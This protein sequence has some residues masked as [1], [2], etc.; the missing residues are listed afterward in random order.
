MEGRGEIDPDN[1]IEIDHLQ[2]AYDGTVV[3]DIDAYSF[4]RG[5][6]YALV[7]PNGSGKSTLLMI[8]SLLAPFTSGR[9]T[10]DGIDISQ[11]DPHEI[12]KRVTL[13]HQE[14]VMF[15]ASVKKNA[16]MGLIYRDMPKS[17]M[18]KRISEALG[19]VGM[20][21]LEHRNART[22][23]GGEKKRTAIA[24][25]LAVSP[26]ILLFDEPTANV[27]A[28]NSAKIEEIIRTINDQKKTTI[29]FSTHNLN[30]AYRL[31]DE[32]LTLMYGRPQ[33]KSL[34][35]I[36]SGRPE[37]LDK[38]PVFNTGR[39]LIRLPD[40]NP[41]I[42]QISIDPS[43]IIISKNA[44]MTSA[45]NLFQGQIVELVK[46]AHLIGVTVR[47][48]EDFR[49]TITERSFKEMGLSIGEDVYIA[50]KATAVTTY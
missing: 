11:A 38:E 36:F 12:R 31:S 35:N 49:V 47:A 15:H 34:S 23:S 16:A 8:L 24:R 13:V 29:I 48:E 28:T 37:L 7:G 1:I 45:R 14:P 50:F 9:V 32:V 44:A 10:L 39:I 40:L 19:A 46:N 6:V 20:S 17:E 30:Q 5:R 22:L 18:S 27:D 3:L 42:H 2:Q 21:G 43:D 4:K 26:D 25:A 41:R 33:E